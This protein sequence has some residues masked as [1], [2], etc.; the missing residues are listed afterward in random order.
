MNDLHRPRPAW[1]PL[2]AFGLA[3]G[4]FVAAFLAAGALPERVTTQYPWARQA[5][6]Q[7]LMAAVALV[8]MAASGRPFA[9]ERQAY[10]TE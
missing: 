4:V 5:V 1:N 3:L 6:T 9:D 7:G 2:V 10:L 8:A